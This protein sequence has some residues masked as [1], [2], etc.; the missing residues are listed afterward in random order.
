MTQTPTS[1]AL[2]ETTDYDQFVNEMKRNPEYRT[3]WNL[4][5]AFQDPKNVI[6]QPKVKFKEIS[7]IDK[8]FEKLVRGRDVSSQEYRVHAAGGKVVGGNTPRYSITGQLKSLLGLPDI[9]LIQAER[10]V[11]KLLGKFPKKYRDVAFGFDVGET[12]SGKFKIIETNPGY[13]GFLYTT[14][15]HKFDPLKALAM[16]RMVSDLQGQTTV[17][18]AALRA[19]L[20]GTAGAGAYSMFGPSFDKQEKETK[21]TNN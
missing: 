18:L 14:T 21:V 13:S 15:P 17:P 3:Y 10:H 11:N 20:A 12:P 9:G 6:V 8:L 7:L 19:G 5:K 1:L 4:L 2:L 16:N